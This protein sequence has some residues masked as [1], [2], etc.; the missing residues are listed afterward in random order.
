MKKLIDVILA[1]RDERLAAAQEATLAIKV[2]GRGAARNYLEQQLVN[3]NRAYSQRTYRLA[4]A[5]VE[6][7]A[8]ASPRE[9]GIDLEY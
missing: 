5:D 3:P 8:S 1:R 2:H 9:P 6:S 7:R 4:I